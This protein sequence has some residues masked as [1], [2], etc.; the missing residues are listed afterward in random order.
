MS[1]RVCDKRLQILNDFIEGRETI[2]CNYTDQISTALKYLR[3]KYSH[4]NKD[5]LLIKAKKKLK[6]TKV[7]C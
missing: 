2:N 1:I 4:M 3:E 7:I 5:S 6:Q